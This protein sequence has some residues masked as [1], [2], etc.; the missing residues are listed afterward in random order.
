MRIIFAGDIVGDSALQAVCKWFQHIKKND[1]ADFCLVNGENA[2]EGAGISPRQAGRLLDSGA[3]CI[4]LGNHV[5]GN[6]AVAK[7][8][9]RETCIIRPGNSPSGWPGQASVVLQK[10]RQFLEVL[11]L[12]GAAYLNTFSCPFAYLESFL[13][14]RKESQTP[15][16]KIPLLVDFH[17]EATGEKAALAHRFAGQV[18]AILGTHTHV[19]TA[20]EQILQG[21]TGFISDLG[22]CGPKDSIIGMD[23]HLAMRRYVDKLP[24]AYKC[25]HGLLQIRAV[26][27]DIDPEGACSYI[28]RIQLDELPSGRWDCNIPELSI[29]E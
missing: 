19:Q 24:S 2:A 9:E 26:M 29:K 25:A 28:E 18:S 14:L 16:L 12:Q 10:G 23:I 4:T 7:L 3:D 1:L 20:D 13:D 15:D 21:Y 5:W 8:M 11:S 27:L 6:W 22:M 17:A